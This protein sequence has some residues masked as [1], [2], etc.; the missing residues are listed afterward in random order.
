MNKWIKYAVLTL[1]L[2]GAGVFLGYT[3]GKMRGIYELLMSPS[4]GLCV[5]LLWVLAA[6]AAFAV[7]VGLVAAFLRPLWLA[8]VAYLI[9]SLAMVL[10]LE[11]SLVSG[12]IGLGL[13]IGSSL[14]TL[15]LRKEISQRIKFS[16]D[17]IGRAQGILFTTLILLI[18]AIIYVDSAD[19]ISIQGFVIPEKY[20]QLIMQPMQQQV[21]SSMPL[22]KQEEAKSMFEAQFRGM[23]DDL[24]QKWIIP[25]EKYLPLLIAVGVF[26][27]LKTIETFFSWIPSVLLQ[28]SLALLIKIKFLREISETREITRL[29]IE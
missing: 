14:F 19:H 23:L 12:L 18:C 22:E 27:A 6:V 21:I 25:Y 13:L 8:I 17:A 1:L 11:I 7:A 24:Y 15:N 20:L 28:I 29:V 3:L 16:V 10:S 2:T 26:S 9:A 5:M 4:W